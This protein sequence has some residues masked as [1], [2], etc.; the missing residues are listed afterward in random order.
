MF[1][2][3]DAVLDLGSRAY[4]SNSADPINFLGEQVEPCLDLEQSLIEDDVERIK[5]HYH[6][7][8]EACEH[9]A[10]YQTHFDRK[11]ERQLFMLLK[12]RERREAQ[13]VRNSLEQ[14]EIRFAK[15]QNSLKK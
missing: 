8:I 15:L 4:G 7:D 13:A 1:D 2:T 6:L 9:L 5:Q 3:I 10:R 14:R 12:L 11:F